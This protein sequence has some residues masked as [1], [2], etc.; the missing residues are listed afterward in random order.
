M[1]MKLDLAFDVTPVVCLGIRS[2]EI[3]RAMERAG[4]SQ[5]RL[6]EL[7]GPPWY[8]QRISRL[9]AKEYLGDEPSET[10]FL[11]ALRDLT[12]PGAGQDSQ[13]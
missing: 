4:L 5:A 1:P 10:R 3:V 7:L 2:I 6:A 8:Q 12:I 9:L 11:R 13:S